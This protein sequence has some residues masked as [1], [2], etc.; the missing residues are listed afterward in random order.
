MFA[1]IFFNGY[2]QYSLSEQ[3]EKQPALE[4]ASTW[5]YKFEPSEGFTNKYDLSRNITST[6]TTTS[7]YYNIYY[8]KD[9]V[10]EYVGKL[11]RVRADLRYPSP[12]I[13]ST[14]VYFRDGYRV[15]AN[16]YSEDRPV[17]LKFNTKRWKVNDPK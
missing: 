11:D 3:S 9:G 6:I 15:A 5:L 14:I 4:G 10:W 7:S 13:H 8:A 2:A 17:E 1:A 16:N 12:N